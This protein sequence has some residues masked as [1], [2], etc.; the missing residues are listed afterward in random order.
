MSREG[1]VTDGGLYKRSKDFFESITS[2][3]VVVKHENEDASKQGTSDDKTEA[4]A[5]SP[6]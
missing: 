6:F 4:P 3:D 2:G 5:E 1:P